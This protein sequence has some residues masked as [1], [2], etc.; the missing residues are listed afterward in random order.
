MLERKVVGG[1]MYDINTAKVVGIV[2]DYESGYCRRL[3]R[4]RNGEDFLHTQD[5]YG[6]DKIRPMSLDQAKG[7]VLTYLLEEYDEIFDDAE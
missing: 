7:W 1:K 5:D 4:K 6:E 2:S 3:Y